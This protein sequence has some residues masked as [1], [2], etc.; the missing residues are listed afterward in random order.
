[1]ATV[2]RTTRTDTA[3]TVETDIAWLFGQAYT[4]G[5]PDERS[6]V[7]ADLMRGVGLLALSGIAQ[8]RFARIR[9]GAAWPELR[10]SDEDLR[11]VSA[12]DVA[13]LVEQ[14]Q[15]E[16]ADAAQGLA[17]LLSDTPSIAASPQAGPLQ[18]L[19]A[20]RARAASHR[21]VDD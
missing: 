7:V 4:H 11:T 18:A 16:Q 2:A 19:L 3:A 6:R 13:A 9:F 10:V 8:G 12:D 17:R 20:A 21:S 14:V 15:L 5:P 1:M